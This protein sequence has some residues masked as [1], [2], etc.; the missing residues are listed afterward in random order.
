MLFPSWESFYVIV[1][2]AAGA[3]TGLMFVVIAL[4]ADFGG[5]AQQLNAFGTPTVVHFGNVLLVSAIMV[6]P[7]PS[8]GIARVPLLLFAACAVAYTLVVVRRARGQADYRPVFEDWL[9]HAA[10]PLAAYLAIAVAAFELP[11]HPAS[12]PFA[13]GG[14]TVLLLLVGLHN[15]WDTITYIIVRNWE[16]RGRDEQPRA[17]R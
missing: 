7:W 8:T 15:S 10:L 1:G 4:V 14:G 11:V 17:D 13:I 5:T 12:A 9:F 2:S 16:R 6:T 3:L